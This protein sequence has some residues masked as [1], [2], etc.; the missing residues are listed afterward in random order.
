MS[1]V[2]I[3]SFSVRPWGSQWLLS[4]VDGTQAVVSGPALGVLQALDGRP[5]IAEAYA[6]YRDAGHS[7]LDEAE[8]DE[9]ARLLAVKLADRASVAQRPMSH[10]W[11]AIS[12]SAVRRL[13]QPFMPLFAPGAAVVTALAAVVGAAMVI[14]HGVLAFGSAYPSVSLVASIAV[15]LLI[16]GL[17]HELGHAAAAKRRGVEPGAIGVGIYLVFPVFWADLNASRVASRADRLWINAGGVLL[18]W[19][20]GALLYCAALGMDAPALAHAASASVLMGVWQLIP[21]MRNDGYWLL[22]DA[23]GLINLGKG[24]V[25]HEADVVSSAAGWRL[26]FVRIYR[27]LNAAVLVVA[28]AGLAWHVSYLVAA[29]LSWARSG[30]APVQLFNVQSLVTPVLLFFIGKSL[31]MGLVAK[32]RRVQPRGRDR[33]HGAIYEE[34]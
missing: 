7:M 23:M 20:A 22:S 11:T 16:S 12:A 13:C 33:Q 19:L 34:K 31:L 18:Q 27:A 3:P 5:V 30:H 15:V 2:A 8:F 9:A 25:L 32:L 4:T 10:S 24:N 14:G 6:A 29:L 1:A 17:F 26:I 28:I 21:F